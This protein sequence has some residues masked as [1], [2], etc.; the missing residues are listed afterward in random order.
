LENSITSAINFKIL[1][2]A[3]GKEE[4]ISKLYQIKIYD[5]RQSILTFRR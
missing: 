2:Y 4:L 5:N 1:K 3:I